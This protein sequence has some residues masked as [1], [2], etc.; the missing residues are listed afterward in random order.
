H[1]ETHLTFPALNRS[2]YRHVQSL[3]RADLLLAISESTRRETIVLLGVTPARVVTVGA[4]LAEAFRTSVEITP[5]AR[6][7]VTSHY[8]IDRPFV[9][10]AGAVDPHKNV[11]ALIA[12]FASLPLNLRTS[13]R[14]VFSG[15]LTEED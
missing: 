12:A 8:S 2:Y 4:G 7:K 5:E 14:L 6:T 15:K 11:E 3:K 1:P 13:H 10:Y 9:L